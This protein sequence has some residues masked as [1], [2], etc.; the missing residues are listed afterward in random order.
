MGEGAVSAEQKAAAAEFR[1]RL[2]GARVD[3]DEVTGAP[4]MVSAGDGLLTGAQGQGWTFSA[5]AL[6]GVAAD[7]PHRVTKAFLAEHSRLFG[8]GPEAL[9]Q[10][11]IKRDFVGA[12]NGLRTVVWEQQVEGIPVF[13]GLLISHTTKNGELVNLSSKFMRDAGQAVRRAAPNQPAAATPAI[14]AAR[15]TVLAAR[16][17]GEDVQAEAVTAAGEAAVGPEKAQ[18]FKAPFLL[19]DSEAKLTWLPVDKETLRLCWEVILTSRMRGEMFRVLVDAQSGEVLI[20]HCLTQYLSDASYNVFTSDSPSPFSPG[21]ATPQSTQP[22]LVSRTV[23]TLSALSTN[24]SPLGWI[25]DG[26]NETV[27]NNV[28]AHTDRN[29]DNAPDLPRPQGLPFRVF[30]FPLD[31]ATQDPTLY[32]QA[33]V[34]QLFYLNNWMHD[35]LYEL[36]FTEAAGNF[37][38]NNFSRG[39][40]GN[41]AVQADAQDGGGTDNANF[42]TPPDGSAGR[43]QMYIFTGPSPRRDGD[44][45]AE[46]VLHEY[47]HGLSNRRVGGGVGMTALQSEGMGE[48]W[49]DFYAMAL[50]SELG[51]NVNGC[52]ASG[53]Y[54]SYLI[55]SGF[56]T[57]YYFGIRRYPYTT[58]MS[59]NPLTFKDIDPAQASTHPGI[60]RSAAVGTTANEVHNMGEV[61]CVTLWEA[62]AN[63]INKHGYTAGN[64]LMLQLVTDGMNL[65]PANPTY[66]QARDAIL[67]A[68]VVNN[69]GANRTELWAAFAKR[70]MGTSATSPASST[71]SGLVEAYDVPDALLITPLA[72]LSCSGPVGGPFTPTPVYFTLTNTGSSALNWSLINTTAWLTVSPSSGTLTPGG[73]AATVSVTVSAAADGFG[74][75]SFPAVIGFTNQSSGLGQP[76]SFTLN[77][78]GRSMFDDFDPGID[79]AQWSSFGGVVGST[80]LANNYGGSVSAPNSLWFGDSGSRFATTVAVNTSGG[81]TVAF[82]IRLADGSAW[83]WERVDALPSEGVV[84]EYSTDGGSA[85]TVMGNFDT[86]AYYVWTPVTVAIPAGARAPGTQFRWRQTGHSGSSYDHWALDNVTIDA[87]PTPP[88]IMTQPAN[89]TV[90][91]GNNAT[92]TVQAMGSPPLSYQW[93]FNGTNLA[94]ATDAS[95]VLANVQFTQAGTYTVQVT[96]SYGST[97][98]ANAL[99]T[100]NEVPP[101]TPPPLGLVSWYRA[102][103]NALDWTGLY[104]GTP[105]GG[106]GY[107]PG[108]VGQA[109]SFNG[110]DAE[111]RLGTTAGNFGTNDFSIEFWIQTT[112]TRALESVLGKRPACNGDSTGFWDMRIGNGRLEMALMAP[113]VTDYLQLNGTHQVNDGAFH[114][115][116][117]VRQGRTGTLYID[118]ALEV[119]GS[120]PGATYLN[121]SGNFVIGRSACVGVDGTQYFTGL[122]DEITV[123]QQA[124]S[125]AEIQAIYNAERS[126]KCTAPTPPTILLQPANQVAIAGD[127]VSLTVIAAG[128]EPLS[129]QW[130][131]NGTNLAAATTS[132]LRLPNVQVSDSGTYSVFLSNSVGTLLS[133]NAILTVNPP[134]PCAA[135]PAGL[136][137]WWRAESD[138]LD[139]AGGNNGQLVN[140]VTFTPGRVGQAFSFDGSSGYIRIPA[141]AGLDLGTGG[142]MSIECWVNPRSVAGQQALAEWNSGAGPAAHFWISVPPAP[143]AGPGCIYINLV[144]TTGN[145]HTLSSAAGI[146]QTNSYQHV[147][148]T[149]DKASGVASLY[150]NGGLVASQ[151]LGS[152]VPQTSYDFYLGERIGPSPIGLLGGAMDE[153]TLYNRAL[154]TAEIQ[155]IYNAERSGKCVVPTPPTILV[156]PTNQIATAGDDISFRVMAAGTQPLGYQ[157]RFNGTNLSAATGSS[158]LLTNVQLA[159]A[160]SYSVFLS[161]SVGTLLSSNAI[162]TVNPPPPCAAPPAGLVS[163]W[164]AEGNALDQAGTNQGTLVGGVSF[165]QGR[166]GQAFS[167]DGSSGYVSIPSSASVNFSGRMPM[168]VETWVN[169]T[170]SATTMHVLGKRVG[171]YLGEIQY[172]LAFDP[173][174]GLTFVGDISAPWVITHQN[175]PMNTWT[176]LAVTYDGANFVFYIDGKAVANATSW[177]GP[178][179]T[180]PLKI[181]NS[182][183]CELFAGLIDEVSLYSRSLSAVEVQAIYDAERSGKCTA[184]TPPTI[185]L[186]PTNQVALAG[187]NLSLSVIATG[188]QPLSYQWR[189]NGTNL[190]AA[191]TSSLVFANVQVSDSGTYSVFLSNSVGTLVSSNAILTVNPPPPC[192]PPPAGLIGWWKGDGNGTDST[193]T[194]NAYGLPNIYFTNGIVERAFACDPENYPY[195]TYTGVQI[196]DQPAYV[197]TNSLSVEAWIRPRGDGY[198]V[199]FRGDNRSGLDPYVL[200]MQA[201]NTLAFYITDANGNSASVAAPLVYNQ[202]W[203]VAATLDG[204]SGKLSLYTNGILAAQMTTTIRPFGDLIPADSPGIGIGNVNDGGNNFPFWGDIDE[205]SLYNRALTGVEV[206]AIYAAERSGKCVVPTP[207]TIL[208]QPTNQVVVVK[209]N[210]LFNVVATGT[211]PLAYQWRFNSAELLGETNMTLALAAVRTDQAG[212]YDVVITNA[213]GGATSAVAVL[214]VYVPPPPVFTV[215]P[216][217]QTVSAGTNVTFTALATDIWPVAYQWYLGSAALAGATSTS[218]NLANVQAANAGDYTVVA[219]NAWNAATST[220]A[221]L[222]VVPTAPNLTLQPQSAAVFPGFPAQLNVAATGTEPFTYQWQCY[223]TNVPGATN[224]SYVVKNMLPADTGSYRVIVTNSV[225]GTASAE[226]ALAASP[227]ASWGATAIGLMALP[228]ELTNAVAVSAG[229]QHNLVLRRDGTVVAWG[230]ADQTNIPAGLASVLA[231]SAGSD[232]SLALKADG[233]VVA[234]GGANTVGQTNVPA[235]LSNV[236]AVAAGASH[237]LALRGDGMVVA[238]GLNSSGQSTVPGTL[239]NVVAVSAGSNHSIAL[240]AD[241]KVFAWGNNAYGQTTVPTNL[242]DVVAIAA[243]ATHNLALRRDGTV[244]A[245]GASTYGRTNVPA[246]LSNVIAIAAGGFHSLAVRSDG[247]LV[248]WGAGTNSVPST[249]PQVGQSFIP[250]TVTNLTAVAGGDA[251]TLALAGDGAPFITVPP[252]SRVSYSGR[253]VIFRAAAT[254]ARPLNYQ[255]QFRGGNIAGATDQLLVVENA[256][257]AGNYRVVV[258]NTLGAVTSAVATLTLVDSAPLIV[259]QPLGQPVYL[260]AQALLQVTA[261][262]SGPFFYQWRLNGTNVAGATGSSLLLDHLL[263]NQAGTYS[264]VVSNGFGVVSSAKATVPVIQMVAWGAGTNYSSSPN[265][266]QSVI[267]AGLNNAVAAAGGVYHTL[268]VT[269]DRK[270]LAWGLGTNYSAAPSLGQCMVP[271]NLPAAV[272]V[273]GGYMHSLALRADGLVAAWGA[274]TSNYSA[275]HYGQ[276]MVPAGLSNVVAVAAG[277]YH[278]VAL[279]SDG[280][281]AAWGYNSYGQTNIPTTAT[282]VVAIAS[283]VNHV[284]A[285]RSDGSVVHWGN[286]TTLPPTPYNYVAIAAGMNHCLALRNDG[287][288]VSWGGQ[289][290]VPTGLSNVV[291]I[292]AGL[293]HS[294]AL[295]NDGT[296]VTWGATNTYGRNLIPAGLTN[297]MGIACGAYHS[298]AVLGD[299]SPLVKIPPANRAA[300]L[301]SSTN[302][303]VMAVGAQPLRYQ[304]QCNGTN[305]LSETNATLTLRSLQASDAGNYRVV[306]SNVYSSVTS[307][308]ATLTVLVPLGQAVDAPNLVWSTSGNAAWAGESAVTHDGVDAAQSGFLTDNQSSTVQTT[309]TGPGIL[310]FWWKVSSE[311]WFD[312]LTFYIDGAKQAAIAG[313][314]D[315]QLQTIALGGGS[316]T[317]RWTYA[318]DLSVSV[319]A[320]AGWLDQVT[321]VTNPPVITVQPL[322]QHGT[323]GAT[324]VLSVAASGVPPLTYQWSKDGTNLSGATAT[325][326]VIP[327]ATRRDSGVYQAVVTNPGGGT[328]SSNATLVVRSPQQMGPPMT[329]P[330]GGFA[331]S[332]GD[333]DGGPLVAS[334]LAN[335]QAQATTNFVDWVALLNGLTVTNGRLLLVDLDSTSYPRRFYRIIELD[336]A[337]FVTNPPVV[338]LHPLSQVVSMG[339]S[340]VLDVAGLGAPPLKYQWFK[341]GT[342]LAGVTSASLTMVNAT[343]HHSGVYVAVV[344]NPV[345]GTPSSNA[346]VVVRVPQKLGTPMQLADGTS[347]VLSGDA[348]GGRLLPGDL[349]GFQAQASTNLVN[350]ETLS[351]SLTLTNGMLL[352]W[353]AGSTNWPSRF[354]RI[355]EP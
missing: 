56:T 338:T 37:Q 42:S 102:E 75:G 138:A 323:M 333:A 157:W 196:A 233:T 307:A 67:Q 109:F 13:E 313:E 59:K 58:D 257:E 26:G 115:I 227:V 40:L 328:P 185:L 160:G 324:M 95:L 21:H 181:G 30:D 326:F 88:T 10:A 225:G 229:A 140:G 61:W 83:P 321:F 260:G 276:S 236:V 199:F 22:S 266:G 184:P 217:G 319:G 186:Q 180:E 318:K 306:V 7:D 36:G 168:T 203:Y 268:T 101:C 29:N 273:A 215:Q 216:Q 194:N 251:H 141:S 187:D 33:T 207:P 332:S 47:T 280:R 70:G 25:N 297:V 304:W 100:V 98:S 300:Y 211:S 213:V 114:H 19:G 96:N 191:T 27:G 105:I 305:M 89:R 68:D 293:D 46:V 244:V 315:W 144:D 345:G 71:T 126:G 16:N 310:S 45:D 4:A 20:R 24:A 80:V 294:L 9:D 14:P 128:T 231:V 57:N 327:T 12:H 86:S 55:S 302:F 125:L 192:A 152:F 239:T 112:S 267:P 220:V 134:P 107:A 322:S 289:Y 201:N 2:P 148:M 325:T 23:V 117:F 159:D 190:A 298:L 77:V 301:G 74:L 131:L 137:S 129:Y 182:G 283:R 84:L 34:V 165:A 39:G 82:C 162:L 330:G 54:V 172:Q 118:G 355:L 164:R 170:G 245:W 65:S 48:G 154:G 123:Y 90:I 258:T 167:L 17:V 335:F 188:T 92:F 76:R 53:A 51:D 232:H 50:L 44:L 353:D 286:L 60:P 347:A 249:Y 136:V 240:R 142:G 228:I 230:A 255:W 64:Q 85:W 274:G 221:T 189:L 284:L 139:F 209:S 222:T 264:V 241:G 282:N 63:L 288:V 41:D 263:V 94:G 252:V 161:N 145:Y 155:A 156:Q 303:S 334:D 259:S 272:G 281:V 256:F 212:S 99:L 350:W 247:T 195:G 208:L 120:T 69:G 311:E 110:T 214:T 151:V 171:C 173:A 234:W 135:P 337:T 352:L 169:R 106:L 348:D 38:S 130:R 349:P 11:R 1:G 269:A 270:V 163:W 317:L 223:G 277:D 6:A 342:N 104:N 93:R 312:Y 292:A 193:G 316:H 81:G 200:S 237:S 108:R 87:G 179:N 238:W 18:K 285:L 197:L 72:G 265:Y 113:G 218:L 116:A 331:L 341:D 219:A 127:D 143:G 340:V 344:S 202:W 178:A 275:P 119:T 111:V 150:Y 49:S 158:L 291:E 309:V 296:V 175:L 124:L 343:R 174:N 204:A 210:A 103:S 198:Y 8:F 32:S 339:A 235:N 224:A 52:Y 262:G 346:T 66:L 176:H 205:V 133:S 122:L 279:K 354:Y 153:M 3:S 329:L 43:M 183:N 243:G 278:S 242:V 314:V 254:G 97:N 248:A 35:K 287:T 177:L 78:V 299:G 320:D 28:D 295:R 351:N 336:D 271:A 5:A 147:A 206:Q 226:A 62:R 290:P 79:L 121:T 91:V 261:D 31:L 149:Y 308:V 246:G 146:V 166:V 253:R 73:A 250:P 132:S 15:A